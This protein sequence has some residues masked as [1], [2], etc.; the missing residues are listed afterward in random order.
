M[1]CIY[2]DGT[3]CTHK[4]VLNTIHK[5]P[6]IFLLNDSRIGACNFKKHPEPNARSMTPMS[7]PVFGT[8]IHCGKN[9]C[10]TISKC[11]NCDWTG[12]LK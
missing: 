8:N 5:V 2:L 1:N 12:V 9:N 3:A 7:K 11:T 4:S 6:C 10:P